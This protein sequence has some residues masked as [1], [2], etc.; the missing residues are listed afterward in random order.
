MN[1][2][3]FARHSLVS[4]PAR[5]R[6]AFRAYTVALILHVIVLVGLIRV[7]RSDVERVGADEPRQER[8]SAFVNPAPQP[9]GTAGTSKPPATRMQT[10]RRPVSVSEP[11]SVPEPVSVSERPESGQATGSVGT[12]A[13]VPIRL[14]PGQ[15]LGIIKKVDPVFPP[16]MKAAGLGGTVVLDAIIHRDG[17]IGDITVL[18]SSDPAFEQAAVDAVKQWRYTPLP[19]QGI[20][21]VTLRFTVP[22]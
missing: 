1:E 14:A 7:F 4:D 8:I 10:P 17:T 18:R 16:S 13:D 5:R 11:V 20:V 2:L 21:T 22:R 6:V 9:T 3:E 12:Q 15:T 19:H